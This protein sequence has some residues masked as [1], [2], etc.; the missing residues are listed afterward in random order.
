VQK[1]IQQGGNGSVETERGPSLCWTVWPMG[2]NLLRSAAV[3]AFL[4]VAAW[5]IAT[6]F[7]LEWLFVSAIILLLFLAGYFF[8][9]HYLLD[10]ESASARGLIS[11]KKR[12]WSGLKKYYVGKKGVHLSPYTRPS[13]LESFRG[14]YLPFGTRREEIL[15][16]IG[17]KMNR[18]R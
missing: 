16:F 7:G 5:A 6:S 8:P 11:R 3:I 17:E 15:H 4:I 18:G 12:Y 10:S 13:R 9:T 1:H 14:I 2:E